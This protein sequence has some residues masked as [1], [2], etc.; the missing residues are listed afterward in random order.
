[1]KLIKIIGLITLTCVTF[2]Y[3]EKVITVSTNQDEIMIKI[4]EEAN[5]S[6]IKA[7]NATITDDTI[8]PGATGNYIDINASYKQMQKIGYYESSLLIYKN[9]YPEISIYNNYDKYII[10]GNT[11]IKNISLIY[12]LSN[13]NTIDNILNIIN[14]NN[15]KINFFVDSSF[16]NNNINII[17]KIK[18]NE[19]YNYGNNGKYTK[20]NLIIT[21]NII[22][23]KANNKAI[24]CLF[25]NKDDTSLNNCANNKMLSILPK[26]NVNSVNIKDN[27]KNGNIIL[28][29]NTQELNSI[30]DTILSKGFNIVPLSEL[31]YE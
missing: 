21:N 8:I 9:I 24:Y 10:S 18:N 11:K 28:L 17:D 27:L 29:N 19:I 22:N 30:I 6:N 14:K 16:L 26:V 7:T 31:I 23:N 3:T 13:N 1:M 25:I 4:K 2:F 12:I 20:D 15:I 5:N